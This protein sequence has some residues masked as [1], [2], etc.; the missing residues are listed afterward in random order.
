MFLPLS[1]LLNPC[2]EGCDLVFGQFQAG[3]DRRHALRGLIGGDAL[4]K[5]A[6]SRIA[7][8]DGIVSSEVGFGV[9]FN[10]QPKWDFLG[11]GVRAMAQKTLV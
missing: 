3:V 1:A 2:P 4:D 5:M 8:D 7:L 10:I 9:G 6:F 11:R